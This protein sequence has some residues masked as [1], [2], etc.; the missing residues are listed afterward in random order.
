MEILQAVHYKKSL[1]KLRIF[2]TGREDHAIGVAIAVHLT[3]KYE[4]FGEDELLLATQKSFPNIRP[5]YQS[6]CPFSKQGDAIQTFYLELK[7]EDSHPFLKKEISFLRNTLSTEI[8]KKIERLSPRTFGTCFEEDIM[9]NTTVLM[10]EV[11]SCPSCPHMMIFFDRVEAEKLFFI[12]LL[13]R[14]KKKKEKSLEVLLK[15]PD[16]IF[17]FILDRVTII[18]EIEV[19]V[20]HIQL[21]KTPDLMRS[22]GAVHFALARKK[23]AALLESRIGEIRD[24][25]GGLLEKKEENVTALKKAFP[26]V[27]GELIDTFF[28][29]LYPVV[30]QATLS[31]ELLCHFFRL[32]LGCSKKSQKTLSFFDEG[33]DFLFA[34]ISSD[35]D[36]FAA[37]LKNQSFPSSF[38]SLALVCISLYGTYHISFF[39][40]Y[41][42]CQTKELF[43]KTLLD[44]CARGK[45]EKGKICLRISSTAKA[46]LDP[47]RGGDRNT[48]TIL[49]VLFDGLTRFDEKGKPTLAL[50]KSYS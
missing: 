28:H 5:V 44:T 45:K 27:E 3:S 11:E 7:K 8:V 32:F 1:A 42:H 36:D 9:K 24:Y 19:N 18:G 33:K 12:L 47:R 21:T 14:Q 43:K 49:R 13:V 35:L 16:P 2:P 34:H 26:K 4:Y 6:F 29:S 22:D 41:A 17:L 40:T 30:M 10:R 38:E 48:T 15:K 46:P 39:L 50:A 37:F 20:F 31:T 23:I 25:N